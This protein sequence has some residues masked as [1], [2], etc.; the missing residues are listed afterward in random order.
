MA[1]LLAKIYLNEVTYSSAAAVPFIQI[2]SKYINDEQ[3][4]EFILKFET[5]CFSMLMGLEKNAEELQFK[6]QQLLLAKEQ[7]K[8]GGPKKLLAL[9][10]PP[11]APPKKRLGKKLTKEE[12][13]KQ[14][15]EQDEDV[16]RRLKKTHI[17]EVTLKI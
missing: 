17:V 9:P 5:I 6:H 13:L 14:L 1:D 12:K 15:R 3:M 7:A 8:L 11:Q 4:L 16:T 2:C 10:A